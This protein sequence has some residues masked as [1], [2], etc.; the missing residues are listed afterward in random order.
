MESNRMNRRVYLDHNASTPVHP[1]VLAEMLPYFAE[2]FGNPSSI[3]AF[4]REA[5]DGLDR[6]RERVARFLRVTPQ[7]IVFTSG[8]TESDNFAVKGLAYARGKGH[9]ITS[10]VEHHAVLRTCQAL[11]AQGFDVTYVG[12]DAYGRRSE[13]HTSELQSHHDL[14]CRLLL[15]K[16]KKKT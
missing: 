1:E 10:K 8:G 6:A 14:V 13:E 11:E 4:G 15:E 2:I 5:R 7:E 9:L 16:K 12:V 3:H